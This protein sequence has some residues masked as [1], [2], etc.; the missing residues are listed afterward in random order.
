ML[1]ECVDRFLLATLLSWA[2]CIKGNYIVWTNFRL[3][4][5]LEK[6]YFNTVVTQYSMSLAVVY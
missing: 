5:G 6:V 3:R 2:L 4:Y 1:C